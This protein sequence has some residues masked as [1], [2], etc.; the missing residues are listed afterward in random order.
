MT[1]FRQNIVLISTH[2]VSDVEAVASDLVV[3]K[4]GRVLFHGAPKALAA[5]LPALVRL[6]CLA[7]GAGFF[8]ALIFAVFVP[9]MALFFGEY[10]GSN[11]PFEILLLVLCFLALNAPSLF[12]ADRFSASSLLRMGVMILLTAA[13]LLL[14]LGRRRAGQRASRA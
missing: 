12:I 6:L 10:T 13:M 2:I 1:R 4:K 7:D 14:S 11:R 9:S 8:S 3:L 5:A